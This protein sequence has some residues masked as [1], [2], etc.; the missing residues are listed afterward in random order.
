MFAFWDIFLVFEKKIYFCCFFY[1]LQMHSIHLS[2]WIR[3]REQCVSTV[4]VMSGPKVKIFNTGMIYSGSFCSHGSV[5]I[6]TRQNKSLIIKA[7]A[8]SRSLVLHVVKY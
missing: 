4:T 3:H 2:V 7:S 6:S 1:A 8:C 5:V